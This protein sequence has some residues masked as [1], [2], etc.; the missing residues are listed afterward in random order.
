MKA[1]IFIVRLLTGKYPEK[2]INKLSGW[3]RKLR[4]WHNRRE[5]KHLAKEINYDDIRF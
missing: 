1:E 4:K 2:P 3:K 5:V